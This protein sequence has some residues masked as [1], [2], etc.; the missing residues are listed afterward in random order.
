MNDLMRKI[1]DILNKIYN[2]NESVIM[3]EL[4]K[5]KTN[6]ELVNRTIGDLSDDIEDIRLIDTD[7]ILNIISE[8]ND[9]DIKSFRD[10]IKKIRVILNGKYT[11]NL[12]IDLSNDQLEFLSKFN[13]YL[14]SVL[15]KLEEKLD[16]I[17]LEGDD[18][19]KIEEDAFQ[20]ECLIEDKE[21]DN[22]PVTEDEF[23]V[24]YK[25]CM[26]N[27]IPN[28]LKQQL[29][30]S[31]KKYNDSLKND[32]FRVIINLDELKRVLQEEY[33]FDNEELK[34][35]DKNK[36]VILRKCN[37]E[38]IREIL[39]FM[40]ETRIYTRFNKDRLIPILIYSNVS[41]VKERY[42]E[43][44][45]S[46]N[47]KYDLFFETPSVWIC[48]NIKN[49]K[50]RRKISDKN[51]NRGEHSY[52]D[53][54]EISYEEIMMN[55]TFLESKGF[56]VS[57][58]EYGF[59][60]IL[61][62]P[63]YK[64]LENYRICE[65]YGLLGNSKNNLSSL[66]VLRCSDLAS[67]IDKFIEAGLQQ[68]IYE[69]PSR[70]YTSDEKHFAALYKLRRNNKNEY[71]N[72]IFSK[73]HT[74]RLSLDFT[75]N[76][77]GYDISDV[78]TFLNNNDRHILDIRNMDEYNKK[79][80]NEDSSYISPD[81]FNEYSVKLIEERLKIDEY[82]YM[83]VDTPIS[84]LKFLRLY[85]LL[86]KNSKND[87]KDVFMYSLL[88]NTLISNDTYKFIKEMFGYGED[89]YGLPKKI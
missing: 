52:I 2:N 75:K 70:L 86:S 18:I 50:S 43:L 74:G 77:F 30:I 32:S 33:G 78:T 61:T 88:Y 82:T 55:A 66:S 85:S 49:K 73:T 37:I 57:F 39:D 80:N 40:I 36:E 72:R 5:I 45:E 53:A 42:E 69:Y 10:E 25:I 59:R 29:L 8:Y 13:S 63:N 22:S 83:F 44:V 79:I 7:E 68:Y 46:N 89:I 12:D 19:K 76:Y 3:N 11:K 60:S 4:S 1:L 48:N 14:K 58:N 67:S 56:L 47:I 23:N 9:L 16:S 28:E 41:F 15:G 26:I 71:E 65:F 64:L 35:I 51:N 38:S 34:L 24:I 54:H 6:I 17:S 31:I 27:E 21:E 62:T 87:K 81:I 20:F 84:R